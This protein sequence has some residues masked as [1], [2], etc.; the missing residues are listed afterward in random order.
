MSKMVKA[1]LLSG[2]VFPGAGHLYLKSYP[3][4]S[5][6]IVMTM[7]CLSAIVMDASQRAMAIVTQLEIEGGALDINRII[8]LVILSSESSDSTMLSMASTG[9][10]VCWLLALIDAAVIA[11]K[12]S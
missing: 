10:A 7:A 6:F 9:L 3:R 5:G 2:L 8:E 1:T 4:G 12:Q 11:R